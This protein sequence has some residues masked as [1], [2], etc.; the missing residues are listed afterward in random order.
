MRFGKTTRKELFA[1]F[2]PQLDVEFKLLE[3]AVVYAQRLAYILRRSSQA[4]REREGCNGWQVS[5][6]AR[7][8]DWNQAVI[9]V[10]SVVRSR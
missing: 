10:A 6:Q 5:L 4:I 1:D 3:I 7:D 8:K 2:F 9:E